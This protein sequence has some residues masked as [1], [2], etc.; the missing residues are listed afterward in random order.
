[1]PTKNLTECTRRQAV[2]RVWRI[3]EILV[4]LASLEPQAVRSARRWNPLQTRNLRANANG[5]IYQRL[6]ELRYNWAHHNL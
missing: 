4:L 5:P 3:L 1:M 2:Q 6:N